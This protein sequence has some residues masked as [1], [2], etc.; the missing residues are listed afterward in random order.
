MAVKCFLSKEKIDGKATHKNTA[1]NADQNLCGCVC[2]QMQPRTEQPAG[3][4]DCKYQ[5]NKQLGFVVADEQAGKHAQG[6]AYAGCVGADFPKQTNNSNNKQRNRGRTKNDR[7][8]RGEFG[9]GLQFP[10]KKISG[11][12]IDNDTGQIRQPALCKVIDVHG[13]DNA[14]FLEIINDQCWC[15]EGVQEQK[16]QQTAQCGKFKSADA[17]KFRGNNE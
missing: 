15:N 2:I 16:Q 6:T 9:D 7:N 13:A 4:E 12:S 11:N 1:N 14:H 17:D 3:D 8:L 10:A 5:W